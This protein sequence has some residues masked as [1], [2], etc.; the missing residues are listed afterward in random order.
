MND[1]NTYRKSS[2]M[3][4]LGILLKNISSKYKNENKSSITDILSSFSQMTSEYSEFTN[5][6]DKVDYVY[7]NVE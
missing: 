1:T 4:S 2:G 3:K 6:E 7:S 5:T